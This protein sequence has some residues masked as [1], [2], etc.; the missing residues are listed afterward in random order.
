[1]RSGRSPA[2]ILDALGDPMRQVMYERLRRRPQH[3]SALAM[4]LTITRSAVSRHL[5]ILKDA[6]LVTDAQ[7]GR[8]RV[9]S[10]CADGLVPLARW[11]ER[12]QPLAKT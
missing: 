1:M 2:A 10:V 6:G 8:R 4:G 5:R 3:V 12:R 9:Y 11:I 7:D